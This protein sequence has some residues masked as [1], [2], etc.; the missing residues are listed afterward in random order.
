[1]TKGTTTVY[2]KYLSSSML[3]QRR[4]HTFVSMWHLHLK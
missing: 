3:I 1:M 2:W 4:I